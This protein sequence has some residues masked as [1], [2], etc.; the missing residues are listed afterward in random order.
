MSLSVNCQVANDFRPWLEY[1]PCISTLSSV[2]AIYHK[3]TQLPKMTLK[4]I[5]KSRYYTHL[6]ETSYFRYV[7]LL[8]P[9]F[10]NVLIF[11]L[12]AFRSN[13]PKTLNITVKAAVPTEVENCLLATT[14]QIP[15]WMTGVLVRNG[16]IGVTVNGKTNAHT[17]DGLGMLH[18][19]SFKDGEIHY[20]NKFLDSDAFNAVFKK[21]SVDYL[22]FSQDSRGVLEK[23][24][25]I[26]I[27]PSHLKVRNANV[28]VAKYDGQWVALTETPSPV[29]F[30][31]T[32]LHTLGVFEYKDDLP[33]MESC[34]ESA[35]PHHDIE[36]KETV[37]ILIK[38]GKNSY[39]IVYKMKDTLA[40]REVIA[41][42]PVD[43]PSYMHSFAVTE[44][45]IIL[46]E[47]PFVVKPLDLITTKL[48]FIKNFK[49]EPERGTQFTVINRH[50]GSVVGRYKAKPFFAFH[51]I[52]AFEKDGNIHLDSAT[53]KDAE[54]LIGSRFEPKADKENKEKCATQFE[55][56]SLALQTGEIT[57][58][59]LLPGSV[60]F[61]RINDKFDGKPYRYAYTLSYDDSFTVNGLLKVD[62][63]EKSKKTWSAPDCVPREPVF[64][65]SPDPKD[66][67]DG[68]ILTHVQDV[69]NKETFLLILDAKTFEEVG[70]AKA[71]HFIPTT[72]HGQ[73]FQ[74]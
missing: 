45:Y 21:G 7:T 4:T 1:V 23:L 8:V 70:R 51:H 14:G 44:N 16:P 9:I 15:K 50:N 68:V 64:V 13:K 52:N 56:F 61:G 46:T 20:T 19:F 60:D 37:N 71:P 57:S 32:T 42:V 58:E 18:A 40:T 22:G 28:N 26:F 72:F 38:F 67:D 73:Y 24:S 66:E 41:K 29:A 69:K 48:P 53:Y 12:D 6:N 5:D 54:I 17:F 49:W 27:P 65:P 34:W 62:T 25:S 63:Q 39:Y 31:K 33:K 55:R 47:F 30:D 3:W 43:K 74:S 2:E 59:T 35:H 11:L 10:G 36:K